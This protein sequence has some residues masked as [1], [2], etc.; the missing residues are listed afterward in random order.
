[1]LHLA[2][3]GFRINDNNIQRAS[4]AVFLFHLNFL[5]CANHLSRHLIQK[6][7]SCELLAPKRIIICSF[8]N[9]GTFFFGQ[10][11]PHESVSSTYLSM[12]ATLLIGLL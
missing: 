9:V 1:M 10:D 5:W 12:L 7:T 11:F 3:H 8:L 4:H 2:P 6:L